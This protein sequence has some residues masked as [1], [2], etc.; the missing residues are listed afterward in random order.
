MLLSD[1]LLG[2]SKIPDIVETAS[3]GF[4]PELIDT[5]QS[6]TI[7]PSP[8][9]Q[10]PVETTRANSFQ[11][12][13]FAQNAAIAGDVSSAPPS[14]APSRVGTNASAQAGRVLS[15]R[16]GRKA[17]N[18]AP[19]IVYIDDS[20]ADSRIM[21]EI[22][23]GLG[24]QY[25]NV[26]DPLQALPMLIELKPKLIFLDLVMPIAN[27]YEVCSQ[28]RRISAFKDIPVVIVTSNDGIADRVRARI[29]G[30]SGFLGKPIQH[31][32]VSKVLKK[33]LRN[34]APHSSTTPSG[35]VLSPL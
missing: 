24:Y 19:Q 9:A 34:L 21:A 28:I 6:A 15:D 4:D 32:K 14:V 8:V 30:A 13:G 27:G 5:C 25:T 12:N 2:L 17:K 18:N 16:V 7:L 23:E 29:V 31:K 26:P 1:R 20:S 3:D 33:H 10:S 11:E 35:S 22:I